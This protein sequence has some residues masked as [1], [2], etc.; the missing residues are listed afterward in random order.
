MKTWQR[1]QVYLSDENGSEEDHIDGFDT[2]ENA[3][4]KAVDMAQ[5]NEGRFYL[6]AKEEPLYLCRSTLEKFDIEE[7]QNN[8]K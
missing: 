4:A 2:F 6:V 7:G 1:Y 5:K 3:T 8:G